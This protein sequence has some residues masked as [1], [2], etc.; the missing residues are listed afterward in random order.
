MDDS[1]PDVWRVGDAM[2]SPVRG[3]DPTVGDVMPRPLRMSPGGGRSPNKWAYRR[4]YL[5]C[6]KDRVRL[7]A[8]LVAAGSPVRKARG[9]GRF[10]RLE[11]QRK[12]CDGV[13]KVRK[14]SAAVS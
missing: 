5:R 11:R 7:Y 10:S 13:G 6:S 12:T 1:S 14:R 3:S 4:G 9:R 2:P 8:L